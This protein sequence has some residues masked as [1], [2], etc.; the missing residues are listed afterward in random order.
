M[1]P[2]ALLSAVAL[3]A[4]LAACG[5]NHGSHVHD[6]GTDAPSAA[7]A[8][9]DGDFAD[10]GELVVNG[11]TTSSAMDLRGMA[12]VSL[13]DLDEW[14][15]GHQLCVM[16]DQGTTLSM[17]G[18]LSYHPLRGGVTA[19]ED[20]TSPFT[21]AVPVAEGA[22]S[23]VTVSLVEL[24]DYPYFCLYHPTTMMGVVYVR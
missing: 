21:T 22:F 3:L 6:A 7:D 15:A 5:S 13:S 10:A 23:T 9:P 4:L 8:G 20:P 19:T 11:C 16:V 24:G 14:R 18:D 1:K 17:T 2:N 12:T